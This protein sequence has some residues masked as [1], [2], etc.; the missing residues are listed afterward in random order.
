VLHVLHPA[1]HAEQAPG[2]FVKPVL[3][4]V[5]TSAAEHAS[6]FPGQPVQT[7]FAPATLKNEVMQVP[8]FVPFVAKAHVLQPAMHA[9]HVSA[10]KTLPSLH[11]VHLVA[12]V[13][14]LQLAEHWVHASFSRT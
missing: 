12:E 11:A 3:H 4:V 9:W 10:F 14:V 13:H 2:V 6:Q 1:L 7:S 5:Q 8:H